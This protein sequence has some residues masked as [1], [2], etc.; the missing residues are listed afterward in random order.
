MEI[1]HAAATLYHSITHISHTLGEARDDRMATS[2]QYERARETAEF[3]RAE[4]PAQLARPR[5]AI[6]CG[7]GLGGLVETIGG[8]GAERREWGYAEVPHFPLGTGA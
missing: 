6:V 3:L 1:L 5:V 8:G 4:L 7:S 2:S